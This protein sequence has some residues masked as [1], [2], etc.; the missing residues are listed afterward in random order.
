MSLFRISLLNGEYTRFKLASL[1]GDSYSGYGWQACSL[2]RGS[3]LRLMERGK[4]CV[5]N[6]ITV[7]QQVDQS[8]GLSCNQPTQA[9]ELT[10]NEVRVLFAKLLTD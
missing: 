10:L 6:T 9:I 1:D 2:C 7:P 4:L 3:Q 8:D 5:H